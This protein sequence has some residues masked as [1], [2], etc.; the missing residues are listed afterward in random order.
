MDLY[1]NTRRQTLCEHSSSVGYLAW[2][3]AKQ[4]GVSNE[5]LL[6][7][8][9]AS[10]ALHDIGKVDP[11]FQGFLSQGKTDD[12]GDGVHLVSP[13]KK[14]F[15]FNEYPRHNELSL[16]FV[17]IIREASRGRIGKN[18]RAYSE[19]IS[20]AV[21]WHHAQP[22][23]DAGKLANP[24]AIAQIFKSN[25]GSGWESSL[26]QLSILL[27]DIIAHGKK[28]GAPVEFIPEFSLEDVSEELDDPVK[29]QAE[30]PSYK[31]YTESA[32]VGAIA[33]QCEA[34]AKRAL[35]RAFITTADRIVSSM[36]VDKLASTSLSELASHYVNKDNINI[37]ASINQ[38]ESN[39]EALFPG[40]KR[41][42]IQQSVSE[43]LKSTSGIPVLSGAAGCGK[44][45]IALS[46]AKHFEQD[47]FWICPRVSVCQGV[48]SELKSKEYLS[49]ASVEIYTGEIK[50][51][52]TP[53]GDFE[54]PAESAM[55][56]DVVVATI[57]QI[58]KAL[59]THTSIPLLFKLINSTILF[60]EYHELILGEG[61]NL[62]LKELLCMKALCGKR[63]AML[64]S[65]TPN[66]WFTEQFLGVYRKDV[67]ECQSFNEQKYTFSFPDY[68]RESDNTP[69]SMPRNSVRTLVITNTAKEAQVNY[70]NNQH[71]ENALLC[72]SK[73]SPKDKQDVFDNVM[74]SFGK[75]AKST[76]TALRSSPVTQAALN[77]S[78]E[79]L[80]TEV[81]NAENW[82]QRLG[83]L[84]RF[85]EGFGNEM[86]TPIP[87]AIVGLTKGARACPTSRFLASM[88]QRESA[89]AWVKFVRETLGDGNPHG[90]SEVYDCYR[91]FYRRPENQA[92]ISSDMMK[93]LNK[94]IKRV[95]AMAYAPVQFPK[96]KTVDKDGRVSKVS[97]RGE[98]CYIKVGV[99]D[100]SEIQT[101]IV[102]YR[103]LGEPLTLSRDALKG[104]ASKR[105]DIIDF[106][107]KKL[108][109]LISAAD[110]KEFYGGKYVVDRDGPLLDRA[111]QID[112][113]VYVSY[114]AE[115][116]DRVSSQ[117]PDDAIYY[118]IGKQPVGLMA[119][120]LLEEFKI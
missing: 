95:N 73:F 4:S 44:T 42:K 40:S 76:Y 82:C 59:T 112:A 52:H 84:D 33:D 7:A 57:D 1:A 12:T 85:G 46:W 74:K 103:Y 3:L 48:Y 64:I 113:P 67:A 2:E 62:F 93:V 18:N 37:A 77:I 17:N 100:L 117:G 114:T 20:H 28:L 98:S 8:I 71:D 78:A 110:F 99:V 5:K 50:R 55:S 69:F 65:A 94:S 87:E 23:R 96:K 61:F 97:L 116:L 101:D 19:Y 108:H 21:Y 24:E 29:H 6:G 79:H 39:F 119:K 35:V 32:D 11:N 49:D 36:D 89:F 109:N 72:H 26:K 66:L 60:D 41:N 111:C 30:F 68:S 106:M 10:G 9:Y 58:S 104:F 63:D 22:I 92:A 51:T 115:H 91:E 47:V 34:N 13:S 53:D 43:K 45:K 16:I 83:R 86:V 38:M 14:P 118:V 102:S 105:L 56:S 107:R 88:H 15:S 75:G 120:S 90:L 81:T 27:K 80:V 31:Q 25:V 54:T 70:I